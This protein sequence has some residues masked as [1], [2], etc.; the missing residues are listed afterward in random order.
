MDDLIKKKNLQGEAKETAW[1]RHAGRTDPSPLVA[2]DV[3]QP[4]ESAEGNGATQNSAPNSHV[5]DFATTTH[6]NVP[7]PKPM[8]N[9]TLQDDRVETLTCSS[10]QDCGL[11]LESQ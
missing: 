10:L 4:N 11:G 9:H 7:E 1:R 8:V 6:I 2:G 5:M 3:Q